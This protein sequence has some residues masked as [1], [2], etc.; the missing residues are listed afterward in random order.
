MRRH[1]KKAGLITKDG[2]IISENT[3]RLNTCRREHKQHVK[4]MLAQAIVHKTLDLERM[5]Q[6][7]I[8]KKL[9]EI[10]KIELVRSIRLDTAALRKYAM[11]VAKLSQRKYCESPYLTPQVP[12]PPKSPRSERL[13]RSSRRYRNVSGLGSHRSIDNQTYL[14]PRSPPR[15]VPFQKQ[16]KGTIEMKYLGSNLHLAREQFD[17]RQDIIVEQ[18]HCGGN[19]LIVFRGKLEAGETFSFIS[20]RHTGYPFAL[21]IYIDGKAD[22]RVSTCCEYHHQGIKLFGKNGHFCFEKVSDADPCYKCRFENSLKRKHKRAK[23]AKKQKAETKAHSEDINEVNNSNKENIESPKGENE[24]EKTKHLYVQVEDD[25]KAG[26]KYDDDFE[27]SSRSSS[28]SRSR[29]S[30]SSSNSE[31][32]DQE[33]KPTTKKHDDDLQEKKQ[34]NKKV[35]KLN[36]THEVKRIKVDENV[37]DIQTNKVIEVKKSETFGQ[38]LFLTSEHVDS[39]AD[40]SDSELKSKPFEKSSPAAHVPHI[41]VKHHDSDTDRTYSNDD[42]KSPTWQMNKKSSSSSSS[43]SSISSDDS[44][45]HHSNTPTIVNVQTTELKELK[46]KSETSQEKLKHDNEKIIPISQKYNVEKKE[47]TSGKKPHP[48]QTASE[49]LKKEVKDTGVWPSTSESRFSKSQ[50]SETNSQIKGDSDDINAERKNSIS[51]TSSSSSSTSASSK[52][53]ISSISSTDSEESE[54]EKEKVGLL[55]E[56]SEKTTDYEEKGKAIPENTKGGFPVEPDRTVE[57]EKEKEIGKKEEKNV[58]SLSSSSSSSSSSTLSTTSSSSQGSF[59]IKD[60]GDVMLPLK[61]KNSENDINIV[62]TEIT[63]QPSEVQVE[64]EKHHRSLHSE[65]QK[66]GR[67]H[68]AEFSAPLVEASTTK[69]DNLS[70][71]NPAPPPIIAPISMPKPIIMDELNEIQEKSESEDSSSSDSESDSSSTSSDSSSNGSG[72]LCHRSGSV[73]SKKSDDDNNKQM[74]SLSP[75]VNIQNV[76]KNSN[77]QQDV[78]T[79]KELSQNADGQIVD[80]SNKARSHPP[81]PMEGSILHELEKGHHIVDIKNVK[82]TKSQIHEAA[83]FLEKKKDISQLSIV[84]CHLHDEDMEIFKDALITSPSKPVVLNLN[85]NKLTSGCI[86]YLLQLFKKKPSIEAI[87][88]TGCNLG[89]EGVKKL[90]D[91]LLE[92]QKDLLNGEKIEK[93]VQSDDETNRE[94]RELDLSDCN[95]GDEGI[96]ALCSLIRSGMAIDTLNLSMNKAVTQ[97]GWISFAHALTVARVLETLTLDNNCIGDEG[98]EEIARSL[99]DNS[100]LAALD[101]NNIQVTDKGGRCLME[102][103][104]RNICL[105]EINLQENS[106]SEQLINDINKYTSLNISIKQ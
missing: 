85:D 6:A 56:L 42:K 31:S 22:C 96:E 55:S 44:D 84:N 1:L 97:K 65:R 83:E 106:L 71:G 17:K 40:E 77:G 5:R 75:V 60:N 63:K 53:S 90:V 67:E 95:F 35:D 78:H 72:K 59:L 102:L 64:Q 82:L 66:D 48:L 61:E 93:D 29:S 32:S 68:L 91:G 11:E 37:H 41:E 62:K 24:E 43:V 9:E 13:P 87:L 49:L 27:Y 28:R 94:L 2:H 79:D 104:K 103:L 99:Y 4:D 26:N 89:D 8:R 16:S 39:S 73:G 70:L 23:M 80:N 51:S 88:L 33:E 34:Q 12:I 18:Q 30:R 81:E 10:A 69:S 20:K 105:L 46:Q 76:H 21:T 36:K 3:Y 38:T 101:L 15:S 57:V 98:L 74:V 100:S 19:T 52:S 14:H 7:E 58:S 25:S 50:G 47:M 86:E 92:Q 54:T 45:S